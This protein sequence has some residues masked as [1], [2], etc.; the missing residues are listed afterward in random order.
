[1]NWTPRSGKKALSSH[2]SPQSGRRV[3]ISWR[4]AHEAWRACWSR[5]EEQHV[6]NTTVCHPHG[7]NGASRG[8]RVPAMHVRHAIADH[9]GGQGPPRLVG[10]PGLD[11][12][13]ASPSRLKLKR[14]YSLNTATCAG[15][16]QASAQNG[17][18]GEILASLD[19]LTT[20]SRS[21]N[22]G[23]TSEEL[24]NVFPK[25][26]MLKPSKTSPHGTR[27]PGRRSTC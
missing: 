10:G 2:I 20:F 11:H 18:T 3:H 23:P 16:G 5:Y 21:S 6:C 25:Q 1:M 17:A 9:M 19:S 14:A 27:V 26:S 13:G 22:L 24:R 7:V 8:H 12:D 15:T 4:R